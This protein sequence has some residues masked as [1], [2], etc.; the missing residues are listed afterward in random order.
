MLI[1]NSLRNA[2][3]DSLP[4]LI[5]GRKWLMLYST[6]KHGISLSLYRR[7]LLWP[8]PSC[9]LLYHFLVWRTDSGFNNVIV[10]RLFMSKVNK[11]PLSL[12]RLI[13]FMMG[14]FALEQ[15]RAYRLIHE[16]PLLP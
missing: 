13:C 5:R 10:K 15:D 8:G 6:W 7:S 2:V 12:S 14:K 16:A 9:L 4:S 1:S 3:Y 11:P